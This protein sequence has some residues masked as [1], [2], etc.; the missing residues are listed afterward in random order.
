MA[1]IKEKAQPFFYTANPN[2][3]SLAVLIHGF[4]GTLYD[5]R[6]IAA[7]LAENGINAKGVLMSGHGSSPDDLTKTNAGD[8]WQ[9]INQEFQKAVSV[10]QKIFLV[11]YSF[12]A[13]MAI[14][15]AVRYPDKIKAIILLGPSLYIR[16]D[17]LARFFL[18]F[19]SLYSDYQPKKFKTP[20]NREEY[21]DSGAYPVIPLKCL[22]EFFRFIDDYTKKEIPLL[23]ARTLI[24][25][26]IKDGT[27]HPKSARYIYEK[28]NG[29]DKELFL[30]D[31]H[32]HN[33]FFCDQKQE[34]FEKILNFIKKTA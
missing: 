19:K 20:K 18:P 7:H 1:N 26:S 17:K 14:D 15:L 21:E 5:L 16:K 32:E 24:I 9:S 31:N 10:Y 6:E 8:W 23:N 30:L 27:V 4:T 13:N 3:D 22:K 25:Q 29:R 11:G 28:M 34:I 33:P 12:G 2:S